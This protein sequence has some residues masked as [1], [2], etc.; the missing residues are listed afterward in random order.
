MQ[1]AA[2]REY[3]IWMILRKVMKAFR[4]VIRTNLK[5]LNRPCLPKQLKTGR[6]ENENHF[7]C[8][9]G[10]IPS[11]QQSAFHYNRKKWSHL[12]AKK[13][14]NKK[15]SHLLFLF[16]FLVYQDFDECTALGYD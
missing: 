14:T 9:P 12:F 6:K 4:K 1:P 3:W 7:E 13:K 2:E 15:G 11:K 16:R 8:L 10:N 5:S